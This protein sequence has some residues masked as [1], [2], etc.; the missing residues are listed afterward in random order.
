MPVLSGGVATRS[1]GSGAY[2]NISGALRP[3]YIP[4][5][6]E[7][8]SQSSQT[9]IGVRSTSA[10]AGYHWTDTFSLLAS[11]SGAGTRQRQQGD[12]NHQRRPDNDSLFHPHIR[13]VGT[14]PEPHGKGIWGEIYLIGSIYRQNFKG[15]ATMR[16][17]HG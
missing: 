3:P 14:P 7:P 15:V 6:L 5:V 8:L 13:N 1:V 9:S 16:T 4:I 11:R 17:G 2:N 10:C 12:H